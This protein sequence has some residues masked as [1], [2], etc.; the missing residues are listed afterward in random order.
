M[1]CFNLV[2][3]LKVR[4]SAIGN[5]EYLKFEEVVRDENAIEHDEKLEKAIFRVSDNKQISFF[6]WN[7]IV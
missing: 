3:M 7:I 1:N 6:D 5:N 2:Y 4:R